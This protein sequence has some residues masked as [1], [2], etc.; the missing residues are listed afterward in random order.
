MRHLVS[1]SAW[2]CVAV[3]GVA[4]LVAWLSDPPALDAGDAR[5]VAENSL[6]RIGFEDVSVAA[7]VDRREHR[8]AAGG[9]PIDAWRTRS[10]VEGGTVELWVAVRDGAAV[11]L[12][13]RSADGTEQLLTDEQFEQLRTIS[14]RPPADRMRTRNIAG[15]VAAAGI[16]VVAAAHVG[17]RVGRHEEPT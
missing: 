14:V 10:T 3:A 12:L 5:A 1:A 8:P 15:T 17:V 4:L 2:V 11:F 6:R 9:A 16:A 13:D 7:K